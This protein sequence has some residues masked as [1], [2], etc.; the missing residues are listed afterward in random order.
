[1]VPEKYKGKKISRM[2]TKQL[3]FATRE[4]GRLPDNEENKLMLETLLTELKKYKQ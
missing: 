3:V 4:V 1:M 2:T